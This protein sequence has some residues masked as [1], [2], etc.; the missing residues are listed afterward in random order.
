MLATVYSAVARGVEALPVEVEVDLSAGLPKE[1]LVG[2]PDA[3]VRESLHRVRAA[4]N[5]AGSFW[6][7]NKRITINLAPAEIRK[8]GPLYDLPIALGLLAASGEIASAEKLHDYL[9]IG[10]LAL[11]GRVR[12]VR[13][14]LLF[15]ELARKTGRRGVIVPE[16]NAREAAVVRGIEVV[17]PQTLAEAAAFLNN[18]KQLSPVSLD[19]E[20]LFAEAED[21]APDLADVRGQEQAKRALTVTAAGG[22]NLLMIGPP[23]S[24]KSMLAKR[25]PSILPPLTVA[26]AVETT[27]VWSVAGKLP[28]RAALIVR[29]P[30]RAP[31][32]TVSYP[33]LVGGGVDP[34]PGEISLAHHGVLFL[35]E[36]PEFD[37]KAKEALRQP[38]EDRAVTISRASSSARFP[39]AIILVAAMNPCPCGHH[40]DPKHRCRCSPMA[41]QRYLS[42]VSGPLLDRVDIHL[43]VPHV[44]YD[45]LAADCAGLTSAAA[46]QTVIAARERQLTRFKD[47]S[48]FCNAGMTERETQTYCRPGKEAQRLLRRAVDTLGM[49]ARSYSRI[50]KVARTIADLA[51]VAEIGLEHVSEAV[52]Y[53]SLDRRADGE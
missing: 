26:E 25:L 28:G 35:D 11:D 9:A 1:Q 14:A 30:F 32:H 23:G 50:L 27:K 37:G 36:L 5:N 12:P 51:G 16:E 42:R 22:H 15:A 13:G 24:G 45:E 34:S 18:E 31:H 47:S 2:L 53:R 43:E 38:L 33:G 19:L 49:S 4:L 17:A 7:H 10:E 39:A 21:E 48:T 29:R 6:P 46:R 20:K 41:V 40:G 8:E 3:A 52:Q 44:A